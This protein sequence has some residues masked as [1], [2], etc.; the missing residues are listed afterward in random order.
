MLTNVGLL[1]KSQLKMSALKEKR[2][3]WADGEVFNERH[4]MI[5]SDGGN[6]WNGNR[7]CDK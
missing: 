5:S 3:N 2:S 4:E 7:N 6:W 1:K